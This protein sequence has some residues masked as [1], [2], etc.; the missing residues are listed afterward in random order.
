[1]TECH[2]P[3]DILEIDETDDKKAIKKAYAVLIKQYKP[4][5]NPEKFKEIQ[6]AYEYILNQMKISRIKSTNL[7][8]SIENSKNII[9]PE[10]NNFKLGKTIRRRGPILRLFN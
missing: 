2:Y 9:T 1:M 6:E 7:V 4:D 3:W 5:D 10:Q 8:D